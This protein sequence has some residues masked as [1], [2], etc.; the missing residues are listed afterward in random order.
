MVP[1]DKFIPIAEETGLIV[2][3]GA[4]VVNEACAAFARWKKTD[5][6]AIR[7]IAIN[8]SSVQFTQSDICRIVEE[9]TEEHLIDPSELE[10]E[11]TERL[12]VEH[13]D[14][15]LRTLQALR[16]M[17]CKIAIDDFGTGYSSLSYM[18]KM[19]IDTIKID[20]SFIGE[21]PDNHHDAEVTRAIV[22]LSKSLGYE[23]VA[24]GVETKEQE[25]FLRAL[26]CDSAQGYLYAK[27]MREEDLVEFIRNRR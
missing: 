7:R 18:K 13:S 24:E 10:I 8:V 21:L 25:T 4:W 20:K 12:I 27:P 6:Q 17:G 26:G 16:E 15:N 5:M 3:I 11:I 14:S 23:V 2:D 19:A 22:V 9:C 1:P